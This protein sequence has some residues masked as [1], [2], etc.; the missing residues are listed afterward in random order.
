[1]EIIVIPTEQLRTLIIESVSI[2]LKY[3][4]PP[5]P[6]TTSDVSP[7]GDFIWLKNTC[8]GIPAS[9]LRIKSAGGEIPGVIKFGKRVLYEKA[10][11]MAW[12]RS[13]THCTK[14]T[15]DNTCAQAATDEQIHQRLNKKGGA[16]ND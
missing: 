1:M 14:L 8:S 12:L 11:V 3:H 15:P 2:A 16:K 7:Y 5:T 4:Q 10:T 13:Q 6:G 9:T